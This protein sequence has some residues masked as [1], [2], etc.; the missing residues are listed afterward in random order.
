[1]RVGAECSDDEVVDAVAV[2][3][4]RIADGDTRN[5]SFV[6]ATQTRSPRY[7]RRQRLEEDCA[8]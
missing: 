5:V 2:D 3:V 4:P 8:A 7:R 6:D 1:M